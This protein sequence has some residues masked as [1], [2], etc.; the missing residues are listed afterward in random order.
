M[1]I[2]ILEAETLSEAVRRQ[3]GS[4]GEM[5][6]DLLRPLEPR[7]QFRFYAAGQGQLPNHPK[8]CEAYII[9]GSRH[10]A[11]DLTPWIENL[12]HFIRQV[13]EAERKCLGICFGH[14]VVAQALGGETGR[15]E[16]GWGIGLAEFAVCEAPPWTR[17]A[18][19]FRILVSHQDQVTSL[20]PGARRFARN[21]FCPNGGYFM[22]RDIFCLQGHPEFSKAYVR[23]L[24]NK[25]SDRIG[26]V[27]VKQALE[28]LQTNP[29]RELLQS[30]IADFLLP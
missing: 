20:P 3:F 6:V 17:K 7:L 8:D 5:F 18:D 15:S 2:G 4:Y 23:F 14:Q 11:H 28:S 26:A 27:T 22:G 16:K 30:W 10:N 19:S 13:H 21:D 25:R 29:D 12:K 24:V 1:I 9:T